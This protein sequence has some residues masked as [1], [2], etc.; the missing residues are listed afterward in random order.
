MGRFIRVLAVVALIAAGCGGGAGSSGQGDGEERT[1]LVDYRHDEFTSAFLRYYPEQVKVRQGDAVRFEQEWT[2]E[3]HSVTLGKVVDDMFQY[4]PIFE[5]YDSEE[6]ARA[7]GV[8]DEEIQKVNETFTK[9]PGMLSDDFEIYQPGA[10]PCYVE[11]MEDVPAFS[12]EDEEST[13]PDAVCPTKGKPQPKFTGRQALYNSGFIPAEGQKAN[14]FLLPIAEDAEPGTYSYFCNY[15]WIS[16]GGKVEI[17][18]KDAKIPSQLDV[19][20]QARKEIAEDA[21]VA[22]KKVKEAKA[23]KKKVGDLELPLAGRE[24]DDE[25]AVVINEFLPNNVPAK[26]GQKVTWTFDG[27][28]HTVSFNVPKYFPIF[29]VADAGEV[30]WNPKSYEPVGWQVPPAPESPGGPPGEGEEPEGRKVDV[31]TWD[32]KGGFRSSGALDPGETFSVT[33]T[34]PGTYPYACVLHPQMVGT[35]EVKA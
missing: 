21:K 15:H 9:I 7:G 33:F 2:G 24:A 5:K 30:R 19:S 1:V 29:T 8:T 6:E 10:Q 14:E 3:P 28:T 22:L 13:N 12:G 25:Y 27:I 11:A 4:M 31:G 23:A 34:K 26:V 17:V 35:V 32:G 18:E 20:R 16:M